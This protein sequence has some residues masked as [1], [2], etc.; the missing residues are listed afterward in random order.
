MTEEEKKAKR[1]AYDKAYNEANKEK[2]AAYHKANKE[3]IAAYYKANKEKIVARSK[4]YNEANKEKIAAQKKA[5]R[6]AKKE[7]KAAERKAYCEANKEEVAAE[8]KAYNE[9][10]K[11]KKAAYQKANPEVYAAANRKRSAIKKGAY[12]PRCS[13]WEG[14]EKQLVGRREELR[15]TTGITYH[16]DHI[17]P[18]SKGGIDH[19][20]NYQLL[21]PEEN[22]S[23]GAKV[24]SS[25]PNQMRM[26]EVSELVLNLG[27]DIDSALQ[28]TKRENI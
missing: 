9:A 12:V 3:K 17:Y 11:E 1:A 13:H 22:I 7:K 16:I 8:R 10:K 5:Y 27:M 14:V 20:S 6:E 4:A 15:A 2:R 25:C 21:L 23:K 24:E 28:L 19:P 18:L 26:K